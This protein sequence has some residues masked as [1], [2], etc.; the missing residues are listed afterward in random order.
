MPPYE[1]MKKW[2]E[3]CH[4]NSMTT[5]EEILRDYMGCAKPFKKNGQLSY[6]GAKAY[7]KLIALV[8]C[9]GALTETN[10]ERVVRKLDEICNITF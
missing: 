3:C 7:K 5:L 4:G 1:G 2:Y 9:L 10:S 8:D 6:S